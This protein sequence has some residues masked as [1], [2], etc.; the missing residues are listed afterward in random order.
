MARLPFRAPAKGDGTATKFLLFD[1]AAQQATVELRRA[2][3][4]ALRRMNP[5]D[6][7]G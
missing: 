6:A 1:Y 5:S 2:T 3:L 4:R 7:D